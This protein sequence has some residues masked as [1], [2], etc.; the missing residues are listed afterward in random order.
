VGVDEWIHVFLTL[1]LLGA[2]WSASCLDLF[3]RQRKSPR[4]PFRRRLGEPQN[5]SGRC[6]AEK[7]LDLTG[8]RTPALGHLFTDYTVV[9]NNIVIVTMKFEV[10]V[11]SDFRAAEV[12]LICVYN[13]L[14]L[15]LL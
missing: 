5:K 15:I 12:N 14:H 13:V 10:S 3:Y 4:F 9:W 6:E 8:T 2:D 1:A 11:M 7:I